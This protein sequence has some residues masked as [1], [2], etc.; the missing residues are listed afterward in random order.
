M[1][2]D[3]PE[4]EAAFNKLMAEKEAVRAQSAPLHAK[5][6]EILAQIAPLEA[7]ERAIIAQIKAIERPRLAEIDEKLSAMARATGGK[8]LSGA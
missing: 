4:I 8:T 1:L 6:A 3:Y 5:R 7:Q 2:K